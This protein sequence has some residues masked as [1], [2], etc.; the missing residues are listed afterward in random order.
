MA[1]GMKIGEMFFDVRAGIQ[2]LQKDL[3]A[4]KS[5]IKEFDN[6]VKKTFSNL[7]DTIFAGLTVVAINK[8]S[9]AL[10]NLAER[11]D[12]LSDI[13][14]SFKSLGGSTASIEKAKESVLGLVSSV[15]LMKISNEGLLK[16]IPQFTQ[17]FDKLAQFAHRF[18]DATGQDVVPVLQRLTDALGKGTTK[19]FVEFGFALDKSNTKAQNVAAVF[20]QLQQKI[21]S[22][23]API[24]GAADAQNA[25]NIAWE[26]ALDKIG[27]GI[28]GSER[29]TTALNDMNSELSD[30]DLKEF[31]QNLGDLKA[32]FIDIANSV[33]PLVIKGI[34]GVNSG[35]ERMGLFINELKAGNLLITAEEL[36]KKMSNRAEERQ[37]WGAQDSGNKFA[38]Q[39]NSAYNNL[40]KGIKPTTQEVNKLINLAK[41]VGQTI[42]EAGGFAKVPIKE[43]LTLTMQQLGALEKNA[44]KAKTSYDIQTGGEDELKKQTEERIKLLEK[45]HSDIEDFEQK[46]IQRQ[47]DSAGDN[48]DLLEFG[49][50]LAAYKKNI[51]EGILEAHKEVLKVGGPAADIARKLAKD[52]AEFEADIKVEKLEEANR[53]IRLDLEKQLTEAYASAFDSI[54][55]GLGQLF[56]QLGSEGFGEL[57][58]NLGNLL[59]K[60]TKQ[61]LLS[62]IA[63]VLQVSP[64]MLQGI[65]NAILNSAND[66]LNAEE[67]DKA[68]RDNRGTGQA[69][70]GTVGTAIGAYFNNPELGQQ[71]GAAVGSEIGK[72]F[73]RGSQDPDEM[74][75]SSFA[76]FIEDEIF[77]LKTV[78]FYGQ[79]GQLQTQKAEDFNF[80]Q[81]GRDRF[82]DGSWAEDFKKNGAEAQQV[83]TGLGE[84]LKQTLGITEDVGGQLAYLLGEQLLGNIDNARLLVQQLGLDIGTLEDALVQAAKKGD[85]SW[86]EFSIDMAGLS[87][88]FKPGLYAVG[89]LTG[90]WDSF[91]NSAGRGQAALKAAKDIG[92]EAVEKGAQTFDQARQL[93]IQAGKN[94]EEVNAYFDALLA[95]GIAT[96]EQLAAAEDK[97]LGAA[98]GDAGNNS[99]MLSETWKKAT[100]ELEN[101]A[102]A[103]N[104]LP[105]VKV[106]NL[107]WK[108]EIDGNTQD[109]IDSGVAGEVGLNI[110]STTASDNLEAGMS[111][112]ASRSTRSMKTSRRGGGGG[113]FNV[114]VDAAGAN[115]SE[116]SIRRVVKQMEPEIINRT[117]RI[118]RDKIRRGGS[119]SRE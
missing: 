46:R 117:M 23:P 25:L 73:G 30:S 27:Q 97:T 85:I 113:N 9:N 26:E 24:L 100:E 17:N 10:S 92:V 87:E 36:D 18:A 71:I 93:L 28:D 43:A 119:F 58:S 15:D 21:D 95:R 74:A 68:N 103:L 107:Q 79:D 112:S 44:V 104:E 34:A 62:G 60:E 86:Q 37:S 42:Q 33:L 75:R 59:S 45:L 38:S 16:G 94:P 14:D 12:A 108:S 54:S 65:G 98:I 8:F 83:F 52:T 50:N 84:A 29:L 48:G 57:A 118:S 78:A 1:K 105:D 63:E 66:W 61:G 111:A 2:S 67:L 53:K 91:V 13:E 80:L 5:I 106:I 19:G 35:L 41:E 69:A 51:E 102:T 20:E 22:L 55:S 110:P 82:N 81:G 4:G 70:G 99:E 90:A 31:G 11:G 3:K 77:K 47:M 116:E 40:Q 39:V 114:Y 7:K 101:Y 56:D 115:M 96:F 88:A 76:R 72:L 32:I 6:S 64:E 49:V 89:D 109:I